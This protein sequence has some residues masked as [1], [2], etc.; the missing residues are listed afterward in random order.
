[1]KLFQHHASPRPA[2]TRLGLR[3]LACLSLLAAPSLHSPP[4]YAGTTGTT[5]LLMPQG[6]GSES[7]D[8]DYFTSDNVTAGCPGNCP[9]DTIYRYY[10]EVPAGLT[11]LRIQIFD[12]DIGAGGADEQY[13]QRDRTRATFNT[14]VKYTL[15]NPAGTS[16][17]TQTCGATASTFCAD[18]AWSTL[19][20][21]TT[22][23]I[24]NGHW[25]L[26]VDQSTDVPN[27]HAETGGAA[28]NDI[29]AFGIQA[30]TGTQGTGTELPV[31]YLAQNQIGM[32][33]PQDGDVGTKAYTF[34]PY[35]TSGCSFT[36]NDFDFDL[37]NGNA[38]QN[39]GSMDFTSR[40]GAF[41]KNFAATSLSENDVWATN[42]VSGYT[43]ASDSIDYG[44]WTLAA[45]ISN[46]NNDA[47]L[48]GNYANVYIANYAATAASTTAPANNSPTVNTFRVYFSAST[49]GAPVKPYMEQQARYVYLGGAGGP[50]PPVV[51]STTS[52][53]VTVQVVNPTA[54]AITFSAT[55]LVKMNVPGAGATY[56]GSANAAV[57]QGTIVTQPATGGTGALTWNPGTV[58]AGTNALLTYLVDVKPT[59][60]NQNIPVVGT[61]ASGNGTTGTWVDETGNTTQARATLTFG[62][63]CEVSATQAIISPA[64][65]AD[66][67]AFATGHGAV[68]EWQTASEI[69][70]AGFDLYRLDG[71]THTWQ[72]VNRTLVPSLAGA[73]QGG[74]YRVLDAAA[75]ESGQVWYQV[76]E[77]EARGG[78]RHYPFSV[79]VEPASEAD[80]TG[81]ANLAAGGYE[82]A[83]RRDTAWASRQGAAE[84]A[85]RAAAAATEQAQAAASAAQQLRIAVTQNG[86]YR[87]T[88]A[89]L[90]PLI[91]PAAAAGKK[92]YAKYTLTNQGQ[93]VAWTLDTDG[94]V[95]FYGQAIN[96]IYTTQNVY[97]LRQGNG[98]TMGT[99]ATAGTAATGSPTASF[100][101]TAN[102]RQATFAAT[103]LPL[104][105]ESDYWFWQS[106][107]AGDPVNGSASF[108]VAAPNVN[109]GG[110]QTLTAHLMGATAGANNVQVS[111]NGVP[112]GY[113]TWSG[114]A[115][116]DATFAA[117]GLNASGTNTVTLTALPDPDPDAT[118][119]IVYLQSFDVGYER[120]F[121]AAGDV[122]A[123]TGAGNSLVTVTGFSAPGI[124]LLDLTNPLLPALVTGARIDAVPAGGA[125]LTIEPAA[126]T[127]PYLAVGPQGVLTP[128][129]VV[130]ASVTGPATQT[131]GADYLILTTGDL[132]PAASS[133][134]AL[135]AAQGLQTAVVDVGDVMTEFNYG[136]YSPHALQ[137]FLSYVHATWNPVPRYVVL[138]GAASFDYRN[139]LGFGGE[140]VPTLMVSTDSGLFSSDNHLV[141]INGDGIPDFAVGRLPVLTNA[142]LQSYVAKLAAYEATPGGQWIDQALFAADETGPDDGLANYAADSVAIAGGLPALYVPQQVALSSSD[143]TSARA[144]LFSALGSGLGLVNYFGHAGLDRLSPLGLLTS[145]DAVTLTNGPRL[146]LLAALTCNVNRFDVPGFSSLGELLAN[147]ANG[148]AVGIW[149]SDGLSYHSEGKELARLFYLDL[150]IPGSFRLGDVMLHA[151]TQYANEPGLLDTVDLYTL[152][153]DP[154]TQVKPLTVPAGGAGTSANTKE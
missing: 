105:P 125:Q 145:S 128:A 101:W 142:E 43:S 118:A 1:M 73:P 14:K 120:A 68:V 131:T 89:M 86:L 110:S 11:T 22:G 136:I 42:T 84:V 16:V 150:G 138:A 116:H 139:F 83:V 124:H 35:I 60:A 13:A 64:E 85:A 65:V 133:L 119:S 41:T 24:A 31:Y 50:N 94:S 132:G 107:I 147:Q 27:G 44:V 5:N 79:A 74:T 15:L 126:A 51:G 20:T 40:T 12:A 148:G 106:L 87:I 45:S 149:S 38:N 63:L 30:D 26:D 18:D 123:F 109:A 153:G 76:V 88:P 151:L 77:T 66:L 8:G 113:A 55:N 92:P 121:S 72:K 146:P 46:Y 34:Y 71:S 53:Q 112:L 130:L 32:N 61:V 9:L 39:V 67:R 80:T 82:R 29:N 33:P 100:P 37:D 115:A 140:L 57:S 47:G 7:Q 3:L 137:S 129:A 154:A 144:T 127:T 135:R 17:A 134:A 143:I 62:P 96:S 25:E 98:V 48:N 122:L 19:Y 91:G 104:D 59:A 78:R 21:Q 28:T 58:A 6:P 97:W 93:P 70:T 103:V 23:T 141:D 95:L 152:L 108:A 90:A 56:G 49:G 75:P 4:A 52:I 99:T 117:S 81:A 111:L 10:I 54:K 69:G 36:E 2:V 102:T 114:I